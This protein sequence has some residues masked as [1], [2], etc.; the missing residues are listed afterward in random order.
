MP[1]DI[2]KQTEEKYW[3]SKP[4]KKVTGEGIVVS[5]NKE[6]FDTLIATIIANTGRELEARCEGTPD[7]YP[8]DIFPEPW[9]GWQKD[10]DELAKSHGQRIDRISAHYA[11]WQHKV[12]KDDTLALI[13]SITGISPTDRHN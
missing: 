7:M 1:P 12:T 6:E 3:N 2:I 9:E 10:V 13:R 8:L 11:R 5:I 4:K